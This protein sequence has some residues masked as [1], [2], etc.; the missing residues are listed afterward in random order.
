[1]LSATLDP[2]NAYKSLSIEDICKL[3]EKFYHEDFFNQE[4]I[5]LRFQLQHYELDVPNHP[6]FKNLSSI[7]N[8]CQEL[9]ETGK[10]TIYPLIIRLIRFIFTLSISTIIIE[11]VFSDEDC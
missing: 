6:K 3:V 4:K 9:V 2:E 7:V 5:Q 10:S 8:S 11:R 1:M